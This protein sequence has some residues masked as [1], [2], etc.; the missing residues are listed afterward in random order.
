M[1]DHLEVTSEE[2]IEETLAVVTETLAEMLNIPERGKGTTDHLIKTP[3]TEGTLAIL[4]IVLEITETLERLEIL[5]ILANHE[6]HEN[7]ETILRIV[8]ENEIVIEKG[9]GR[10]MDTRENTEI[11]EIG[12]EMVEEIEEEIGRE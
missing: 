1:L 5:V 7:H 10:E 3:D 12:K 6:S 11:E 4:G 9:K 2:M 8:K